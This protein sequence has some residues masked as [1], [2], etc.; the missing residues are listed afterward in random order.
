MI[1]VHGERVAFTDADLGDERVGVVVAI[2]KLMGERC[3][4]VQD[5]PTV[6]W[7]W[8]EWVAFDRLRPAPVVRR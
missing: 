5:V 8:S 3:A 7:R 1:P 2:G 4:R 6:A